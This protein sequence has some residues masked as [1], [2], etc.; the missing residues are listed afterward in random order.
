MVYADF[1]LSFL[2]FNPLPRP[3]TTILVVR[4][5]P[6]G[7]NLGHKTSRKCP[8]IPG[9]RTKANFNSDLE[10]VQLHSSNCKN[11]LK[12]V[13]LSVLEI[14]EKTF[15]HNNRRCCAFSHKIPTL[16]KTGLQYCTFLQFLTITLWHRSRDR[17]NGSNRDP[18]QNLA[19]E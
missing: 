17:V 9:K 6:Q 19:H 4:S 11:P 2:S 3:D 8:E 14:V 16:T 7:E 15:L 13:C 18:V 12:R 10:S 5:L 1:L